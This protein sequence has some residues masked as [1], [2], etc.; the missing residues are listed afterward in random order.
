MKLR[1]QGD[2]L[3]LRLSRAEVG[4]LE[5]EGAV[6]A[7]MRVGPGAA[8]RY[9]LRAADVEALEAS[10]GGAGLE[11]RVPRAWVAGWAGD[12]RVGFEGAQDAGGGRTLSIRVE[13]DFDCLHKRP[14]EAGL[15]PHPDARSE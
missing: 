14:D 15:F 6:E 2:S 4:G 1:I 10:L 7:S 8:L 5:A 11:V 13:K 9:A 12:D 3:R